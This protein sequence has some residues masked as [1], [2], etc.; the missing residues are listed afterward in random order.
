MTSSGGLLLYCRGVFQA[1]CGWS[2]SVSCFLSGHL[3]SV[4]RVHAVGNLPGPGVALTIEDA[5]HAPDVSG[6]AGAGRAIRQPEIAIIELA[7][8]LGPEQLPFHVP[9]IGSG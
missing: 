8:D 1:S 9:G 5:F 7:S 4:Q 2:Y 3:A 6:K